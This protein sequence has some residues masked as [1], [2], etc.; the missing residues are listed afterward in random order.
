MCFGRGVTVPDLLLL[1]VTGIAAGIVSTVASLASVVSYPVLLALGLPPLSA[2][3]TNTVGLLPGTVGGLLGYADAL[4]EQRQRAAR[5]A[6]PSL[7]GAAAGTVLLLLTPGNTFEAIVPA[8]VALSSLLLLF[9]PQI[10]ARRSH[11][12]QNHATLA[13][14]LTLSGMYA[15]YFG[16]AVGIF[17]TALLTLFVPE[18]VHRLNALK[19]LLVGLMNLLPAVAY[20]FLAHVNAEYAA[21]LMVSSLAGGRAGAFLARRMPSDVLRVAIAC[22]GL[23]L[24]VV[25]A[26]RAFG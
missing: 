13:V 25:F 4:S 10:A 21:E 5:L 14:G 23:V 18:D 20:V 26:M 17:V 9:Q 22:T 16:S 2:N 11:T 7:M 1:L 6:I 8:L 19:I 12:R 24:A 15:A 3:V